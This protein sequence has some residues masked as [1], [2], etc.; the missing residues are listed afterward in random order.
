[1]AFTPRS[2]EE[3]AQ[4]ITRLV[5]GTLSD[6]E[7]DAVEAWAKANP[8]VHRQIV[9]ERHVARELATGGPTAPDRLLDAVQRRA[10]ATGWR[11]QPGSQSAPRSPSR[12]RRGTRNRSPWAGG[13]RP[14]RRPGNARRARPRDRDRRRYRRLVDLAQ[15]HRRR[16]A[17]VRARDKARPHG[18]QRL[19]SRRLLPRRHVPQLRAAARSRQ[20]GS[21][22]TRSAA[23]RRSPST[24]ACATAP[25]SAT[26]SSPG[27]LSGSRLPPDSSDMKAFR[28][29]S[30]APPMASASSPSSVT[31]GPAYW[32]P[33]PRATSSS[34]WRPS[35]CSSSP[36]DRP[37]SSGR[38]R[39]RIDTTYCESWC[40]V[41]ARAAAPT[42]TCGRSPAARPPGTPPVDHASPI[43]STQPSQIIRPHCS[44]S[45]MAEA[46]AGAVRLN[47]ARA[48][49]ARPRRAP[50]PLR[51]TRRPRAARRAGSRR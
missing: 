40:R 12:A 16:A 8:E 30:T 2:D 49:R 27:S 32:P 39:H 31:A 18:Q 7:R 5:D 44:P 11:A 20:P 35:Q 29:A 41:R 28:S 37:S 34:G 10:E 22:S 51:Q 6:A 15:H 36:P 4:A 21:W 50:R 23:G 26:R 25:D 14:R 3:A 19:L 47:L 13:W 46:A 9:A 17:G 48:A 43:S 38:G 1:M 24:T 42:V 45:A 33:P